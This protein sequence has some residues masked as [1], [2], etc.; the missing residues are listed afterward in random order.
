MRLRGA[1]VC[2]GNTASTHS[3]FV[4][5]PSSFTHH[6]DSA[7]LT[8]SVGGETV[9][10][11]EGNTVLE[12]LRA[13]RE[14]QTRRVSHWTE[15]DEA[16]ASS[17][18]IEDGMMAQILRLVTEG[19]IECSHRARAIQTELNH[20]N[21]HLATLVSNIQD[22]ENKILRTTVERDQLVRSASLQDRDFSGTIQQKNNELNQLRATVAEHMQEISAE[23]ADLV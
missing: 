9:S 3:G 18:T 7:Y 12:L 4:Y 21:P 17:S 2:S 20:L 22:T 6:L 13:F 11:G 14:C 19:L 16:W 5:Q 23:M 8:M 15:Y 1:G 10:D